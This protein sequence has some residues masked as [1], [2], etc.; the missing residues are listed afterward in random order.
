MDWSKIELSRRPYLACDITSG[1]YA[2]RQDYISKNLIG[3][4]LFYVQ[5]VSSCS[6][7]IMR[8]NQNFITKL[9][10]LLQTQ[11]NLTLCCKKLYQQTTA[12]QKPPSNNSSIKIW[13]TISA[14]QTIT[15]KIYH[16]PSGYGISSHYIQ[17]YLETSPRLTIFSCFDQEIWPG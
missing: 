4:K 16:V 12:L 8:P 7:G 15:V 2:L 1:K 13:N 5:S 9:P 3:A 6:L 11:E 10:E 17:N 14:V